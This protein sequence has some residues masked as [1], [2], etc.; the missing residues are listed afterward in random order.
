[1]PIFV[2]Q[3]QKIDPNDTKD[4]IKKM[5]NHLRYLQEQMEYTLTNLDS[6]N[7]IE[8]DTDKTVI[9]DSTGNTS[10]G[11]F[12]YLEGNNKE[13]FTCGKNP[14]GVFEFAIKGKGGENTMS[15]NSDGVLVINSNTRLD[16]D[17]GEW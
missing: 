3:L 9:T 11:S 15:L 6:R 13:S 2:Q 8:I 5:A 7:V 4:A 14:K 12:I 10:I 1:M 17:G 16:I